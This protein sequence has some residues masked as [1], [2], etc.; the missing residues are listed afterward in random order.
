MYIDDKNR[1]FASSEDEFI[2]S[3]FQTGGTCVGYY[4]EQKDK[5]Y[6]F[7]IKRRKVGIVIKETKKWK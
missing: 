1:K 2:N 4:K 5:I 3:L 6:L 7:D